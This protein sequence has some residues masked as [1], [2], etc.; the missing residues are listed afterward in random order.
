MTWNTDDMQP[1]YLR[2]YEAKTANAER[3][4]MGMGDEPI[5]APD[6]DPIDEAGSDA[7]TGQPVE[8]SWLAGVPWARDNEE[9]GFTG[10]RIDVAA[11]PGAEIR[12]LPPEHPAL[13]AIGEFMQAVKGVADK[14]EVK[15][16]V[17][18]LGGM[19]VG[20]LL[21]GQG[22]EWL[23]DAAHGFGMQTVPIAGGVRIPDKRALDA[24]F[25]AADAGAL[26]AG[27]K[28]VAPRLINEIAGDMARTGMTTQGGQIAWHGSPHK[29][30]H[31]QERAQRAFNESKKAYNAQ[32]A[33]ALYKVDIPDEA[34]PSMLDWD[35]PL[36]EQSK[37]VRSVLR[38][39]GIEDSQVAQ[40]DTYMGEPVYG[41]NLPNG[42]AY[43]SHS[44]GY[45]WRVDLPGGESMGGFKSSDDAIR[46][47]SDR[48]SVTGQK[49]H[50]LL[51]D[52]LGS[53]KA[54]R[55]YLS[56]QGIPGIRYLDGGSRGAGQGTYNYVLFDDQLP[57]IIEVNGKTTGEKAW[58]PGEWKPHN[59]KA[60]P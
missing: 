30:R 20:E 45:L 22:P 35:K 12:N 15:D 4:A 14:Y 39:A 51:T 25:M 3:A 28:K 60:K 44:P 38:S 5:D 17:P 18:L 1:E 57:R 31:E 10:E 2:L 21:M 34:I 59:T 23:K 36:S 46:A 8:S 37:E 6:F 54:V 49:A 24:G 33:S 58:Q 53:D 56:T 7:L 55:E 52:S 43:I 47:L 40:I 11:G 48:Y 29:F 26:A 9:V 32:K 16:W 27:V 42:K 50:N 19:G 13:N 41:K